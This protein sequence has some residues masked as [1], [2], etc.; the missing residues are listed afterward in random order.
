M[1]LLLWGFSA[2]LSELGIKG[3]NLGIAADDRERLK[4]ILSKGLNADI[5]ITS[6]GVSMGERDF[7][8][9]ILREL[10]VDII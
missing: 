8:K 2:A 5:L 4:E 9:E 10:G 1:G 3:N 7:V 6:G